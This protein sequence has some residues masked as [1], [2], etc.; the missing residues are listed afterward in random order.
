MTMQETSHLLPRA[1]GESTMTRRSTTTPWKTAIV[2]FAVGVALTL[3][4][5]SGVTPSRRATAS[6]VDDVPLLGKKHKAGPA[7]H[8]FAKASTE[9]AATLP[10][11]PPNIDD[12]FLAD[13][14]TR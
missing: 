1:D 8:Y 3:M 14:V 9:F 4:V 12:S 6:V 13:L 5:T 2:S 7:L 11:L 10:P